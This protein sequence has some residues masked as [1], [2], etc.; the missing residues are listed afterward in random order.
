MTTPLDG[1]TTVALA[2]AVILSGLVSLIGSSARRQAVIMA[3]A[4]VR[5]LCELTG[6]TSPNDLQDIFGPPNL[7][8]VW[9]TLTLEQVLAERRPLGVLLSG[10]A[11]DW[12]CIV[13]GGL[14]FF[15][16]FA[17]IEIALV[18][19]FAIQLASWVVAARLPR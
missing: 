12:A 17:L 8:R 2:L 19:A 10:Q 4:Q 5:D 16:S 3:A 11:L 15:S 13:A 1:L 18:T 7:N 6:I 9:Q 14:A